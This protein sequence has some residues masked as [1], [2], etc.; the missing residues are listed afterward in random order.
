MVYL[1]SVYDH[2]RNTA[3]TF[4]TILNRVVQ[5]GDKD[6]EGDEWKMLESLRGQLESALSE[7]VRNDP[8]VV[9]APRSSKRSMITIP[10][11][12]P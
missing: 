9:L 12:Q 7:A 8:S 2:K 11:Q 4:Q 3:L 10:G 5:W 1:R 6:R